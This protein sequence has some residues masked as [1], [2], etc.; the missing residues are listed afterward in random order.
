MPIYTSPNTCIESTCAGLK[1][2]RETY[3]PF[4]DKF[5]VD[6]VLE[7]HVHNYQ[8]SYPIAC[9]PKNLSSPIVTSASES[10]YNNPEGQIYV[11]VGTGG[12]NLQGLSGKT[13]YMASQQDSKFGVLVMRFSENK[14][15]AN[16]ISND[17]TVQISSI[18]QKE[19]LTQILS[20]IVV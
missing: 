11:I 12:V 4:S 3:N 10:N 6:I 8:R 14:L 2:L 5:G 9:N 7:G 18:S 17:G 15:N 13:P 16:F 20:R 19:H 1:S